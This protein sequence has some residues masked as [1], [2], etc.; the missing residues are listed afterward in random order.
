MD[1]RSLVFRLV[2]LDWHIMVLTRCLRIVVARLQTFKK[3]RTRSVR[4]L[5]SRH[6][7]ELHHTPTLEPVNVLV[8]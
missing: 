3:S 5:I 8:V 4:Q 6:T 7:L 2:H 1:E